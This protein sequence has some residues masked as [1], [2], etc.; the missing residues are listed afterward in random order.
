MAEQARVRRRRR[1][2]LPPD[3][4]LKQR[5]DARHPGH[6]PNFADLNA[7]R[8]QLA[9]L[10]LAFPGTRFTAR[11]ADIDLVKQAVRRW[12]D[13][14]VQ[15]V[16]RYRDGLRAGVAE[17]ERRISNEKKLWSKAPWF[18]H[19]LAAREAE[20]KKILPTKKEAEFVTFLR[21]WESCHPVGGGS[22]RG[23]RCQKFPCPNCLA[24]RHNKL[25]LAIRARLGRG[26]RVCL[27]R[28]FRRH[29]FAKTPPHLAAF[30]KAYCR[31]AQLAIR[32][33]CKRLKLKDGVVIQV[34][35]RLR[36]FAS[37][38]G[39]DFGLSVV[40]EAYAL[41]PADRLPAAAYFH[42]WP[43]RLIA[44]EDL[45]TGLVP[46]L[47]VP[48]GLAA[49]PPEW[50]FHLNRAFRRQSRG[51]RFHGAWSPGR[52]GKADGTRP[53]AA[54]AAGH[55]TPTVTTAPSAA[56]QCLLDVLDAPD[57]TV[58]A[59]GPGMD[60]AGLTSGEAV[61]GRT[62]P[63]RLAEVP[64][65]TA[66]LDLWTSAELPDA[67]DRVDGDPTRPAGV[68][69]PVAGRWL[70]AFD[71]ASFRPR[72]ELPVAALRAGVLVRDR[73]RGRRTAGRSEYLVTPLA[74][75]YFVRT[76]WSH[77]RPP[78]A[79]KGQKPPKF[80][81]PDFLDPHLRDAVNVLPQEAEV[82]RHEKAAMRELYK[83]LGF[84]RNQWRELGENFNL[85]TAVA[86]RLGGRYHLWAMSSR[87]AQTLDKVFDWSQGMVGAEVRRLYHDG[88]GRRLPRDGRCRGVLFSLYRKEQ[89]HR[90]RLGRPLRVILHN[91][92]RLVLDAQ[93]RIRESAGV[94]AVLPVWLNWRERPVYYLQRTADFYEQVR[95]AFPALVNPKPV[96]DYEQ[97]L[98]RRSAGAAVP[99]DANDVGSGVS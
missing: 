35:R 32:A 27:V 29:F 31:D 47:Q 51:F 44:R 90:S 4:T 67:I 60:L 5:L 76:V 89:L 11:D 92:G 56:A 84:G 73:R 19:L 95:Q 34:V 25:R 87:Y 21:S 70:V 39:T 94:M 63:I 3:A 41:F 33:A 24:I 50:V 79:A 65:P 58:R 59:L 88:L 78:W 81:M 17:I 83:R 86:E 23:S 45:D 49:V 18:P 91:D 93:S 8:L 7:R 42:D 37:D 54:V 64:A 30:V 6:K 66:R 20:K 61:L 85:E 15:G 62:F 98:P 26:R 36:H 77:W 2:A 71:A 96:S 43:A 99:A 72:T 68:V 9:F 97:W 57:K 28:V 38:A 12:R 52:R 10:R 69:F 82:S 16:E 13:D 74:G 80:A 53:S 75:G 48:K 46:I 22:R 55:P 40:I 1:S 14:V